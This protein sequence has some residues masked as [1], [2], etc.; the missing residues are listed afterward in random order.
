M[1][2]IMHLIFFI[3]CPGLQVQSQVESRN[4]ADFIFIISPKTPSQFKESEECLCQSKHIY[5]MTAC[6]GAD[7]ICSFKALQAKRK[8]L[9]T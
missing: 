6:F 8:Y 3:T 7:S 9:H 4:R 2:Q 1:E 5:Y